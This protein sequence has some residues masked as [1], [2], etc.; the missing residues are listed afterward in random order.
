M[1]STNLYKGWMTSISV[2]RQVDM[3]APVG[4]Q[5]LALNLNP[6]TQN[7]PFLAIKSVIKPSI[8]SFTSFNTKLSYLIII[9]AGCKL[10]NHFTMQNAVYIG[11]IIRGL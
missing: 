11:E 3:M 9:C 7:I 6:L 4:S 1:L 2:F 10:S 8:Q 5:G